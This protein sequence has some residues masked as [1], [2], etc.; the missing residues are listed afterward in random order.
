[1]ELEDIRRQ[2]M[3][4]REFE[5]V[6]DHGS[7]WLRL[8]TRYEVTLAARRAGG[9]EDP[10]SLLILERALVELAIV[11]WSGVNIKDV[12]P[13]EAQDE[14]LPHSPDAV[15]ILLDAKPDWATE[16]GVA[17]FDRMAQRKEE[18]DTA[19]KNSSSASTGRNPKARRAS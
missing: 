14:P 7:F 3:A 5:K 13:D 6:V 18:R 15:R 11:R 4:A 9:N 12:L 2:A 8:P 16:L 17:L 19:A 1:M 10:A